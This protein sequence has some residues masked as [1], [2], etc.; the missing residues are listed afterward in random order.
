[1]V[2]ST[3]GSL[4]Y[5]DRTGKAVFNNRNSVGEGLI[6]ILP[7]L[8]I[9]GNG[10]RDAGE[11]RVGGLNIR[12]NGG[13]IRYNKKD[14]TITISDL[15][16]YANYTFTISE[17]F[18]NIAWH[19]QN[20]VIRVAVD[21][22]QF[23]LVEIPVEV[24]NEVAGVVYLKEQDH[25]KGMG[26]ITVSFY[27]KD[28]S[29]AGETVTESDGTFSYSGLPPGEYTAQINTD[30][31]DKLNMKVTPWSLKFTITANKNGDVVDGLDICA[32]TT[33]SIWWTIFCSAFCFVQ[34]SISLGYYIQFTF[35]IPS[36]P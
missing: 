25:Q 16:A 28:F 32:A 3:S 20:K 6:T 33:M 1:M 12:M 9:N 14:T 29:L 15:E 19:I 21:P 30:Q 24:I 8:D 2:Q 27:N 10:L 11:S 5:N 34:H 23:K 7:Y 36:E 35:S 13:R 17:S 26:R 4:L 18:E 31:S 22:N